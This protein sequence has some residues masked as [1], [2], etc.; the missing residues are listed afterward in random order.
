LAEVRW[1]ELRKER[2]QIS[3]RFVAV[4]HGNKT[5]CFDLL[6]ILGSPAAVSIAQRKLQALGV[7]REI[8]QNANILL[9]R[10]V[11]LN[12][13]EEIYNGKTQ[14]KVDINK[15]ELAG[16]EPAKDATPPPARPRTPP[17][18]APTPPPEPNLLNCVIPI[19]WSAEPPK[20]VSIKKW[21]EESSDTREVDDVD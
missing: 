5:L 3:M 17:A 14:L 18:P 16:Y 21:L 10:R 9:G 1:L 4:G 7:S 13:K 15:S 8:Y 2:T 12:L 20:G 6:T 19:D 11:W